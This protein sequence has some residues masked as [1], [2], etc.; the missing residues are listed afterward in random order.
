MFDEWQSKH[1]NNA[2]SLFYVSDATSQPSKQSVSIFTRTD[3]NE[4]IL[5]STWSFRYAS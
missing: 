3:V 2:M 5:A 1:M 4:A